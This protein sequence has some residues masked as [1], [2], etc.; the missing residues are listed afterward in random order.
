MYH[1]T[2]EGSIFAALS[3]ACNFAWANRQMITHYV[4]LSWEK[5]FG[6]AH[7]LDLVYDVAHNI[8]KVEEHEIDGVRRNC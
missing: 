2:T 4:R 1:S 3:A 6:E 8:A 7:P 5:V